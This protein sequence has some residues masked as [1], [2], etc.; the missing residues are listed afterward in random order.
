MALT[1]LAAELM[2]S[3]QVHEYRKYIPSLHYGT[4]VTDRLFA[5]MSDSKNF[6]IDTSRTYKGKRGKTVNPNFMYEIFGV[7][8]GEEADIVRTRMINWVCDNSEEFEKATGL[9]MIGKD[10]EIDSWITKMSSTKCGGDEFALF[11]LCKLFHRHACIVNTNRLWHTCSVEGCPDED[12]IK[13]RC[14]LRFIQLTHDT[15]ALLRPNPGMPGYAL[16]SV[17][18]AGSVVGMLKESVKS[19]P[20]LPEET[21]SPI[22]S[23][24]VPYLTTAGEEIN[25]PVHEKVP[26]IVELPD[27]TPLS[28]SVPTVDLPPLNESEY[29]SIP[30]TPCKIV[31]RKL[32]ANDINLWKPKPRKSAIISDPD[33]LLPAT[34]IKNVASKPSA[35][36]SSTSAD[37]SNINTPAKYRT[38]SGYGL[39]NRPK[40][41]PRG[42]HGPS[43]VSKSNVTYKG[44]FS[45][46]ESSQDEKQT[47]LPDETPKYVKIRGLSEPSPYRLAA[48]QFISAQ[49]QGLLP[50]PS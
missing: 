3:L 10:L 5:S 41:T 42:R 25:L 26:D 1:S 19:N 15:F 30:T 39:R 12:A 13:N 34:P 21:V 24:N 31:V 11:A 17:I 6:T 4:G 48:Q 47:E 35:A 37:T 36:G 22:V 33:A 44:V 38:V 43:R 32:D 49:K 27:E 50:P 2:N 7:Y 45:S 29:L 9:A 18:S 20:E 28:V 14:D 8:S 23:L 16:G 46:E 40:P